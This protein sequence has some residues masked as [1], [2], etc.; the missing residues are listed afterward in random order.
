MLNIST[1]YSLVPRSSMLEVLV[2]LSQHVQKTS[3]LNQI[4]GLCAC[5]DLCKDWDVNT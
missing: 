4:A 1:E 2:V 3:N 5:V